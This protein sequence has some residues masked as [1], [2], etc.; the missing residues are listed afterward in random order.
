[1]TICTLWLFD[2]ATENHHESSRNGPFSTATLNS[3]RVYIY[4]YI[5]IYITHKMDW[6]YQYLMFLFMVLG[7]KTRHKKMPIPPN[8]PMA[9]QWHC[10]HCISPS[11]RSRR[12]L[13]REMGWSPRTSYVIGS[14][15]SD[16][17]EIPWC[18][19]PVWSP[20]MNETKPFVSPKMVDY[21]PVN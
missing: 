12:A 15:E 10:I 16:W 6:L 3:R 17:A 21:P 1:M 2:V 20:K 14:V 11:R 9:S 19:V 4:V 5:Y 13:T 18:P 7:I 8:F